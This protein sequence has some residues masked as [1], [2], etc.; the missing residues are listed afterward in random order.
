MKFDYRNIQIIRILD[1]YKNRYISSEEMAALLNVSSKTIIR[2]MK[3]LCGFDYDTQG[4]QILSKKGKG[5]TLIVYDNVK[6]NDF[7][8]Y[9]TINNNLINDKQRREQEIIQYLL[10]KENYVTIMDI[11]QDLFYGERTIANDIKDV[12]EILENYGLKLIATPS[13][14]I[15]IDGNELN[16]RHCMIEYAIYPKEYFNENDIEYIKN[17]TKKIFLKHNIQMSDKNFHHFI[18]HILISI[19]RINHNHFVRLHENSF[20]FQNEKEYA[21]SLELIDKIEN[22]LKLENKSDEA[23]YLTI[24]LMGRKSINVDKESLSVNGD[25]KETLDTIFK[26]IF[27]NYKIDLIADKE[28]Y[29]YLA[30]HFEP[31]FTRLQYNIKLSNPLLDEIK[32]K[33]AIAYDMGVIAKKIIY[34][35]YNYKLDDNEISYIAMYF[36]MA[37]DKLNYRSGKRNIVLICDLGIS[38]YRILES[39]IKS[40]YGKYINKILCIQ[41]IE[42]NSIELQDFDCIIT[43]CS[44]D[45]FHIN[46]PIIY[47]DDIFQVANNYKLDM[48]FR[49]E[50]S[51]IF[52]ISLYFP[53]EFLLYADTFFSKEEAIDYILNS[54]SQYIDVPEDLK[55]NIMERE[56]LS[57]TS[58]SNSLIAIPHPIKMCSEHTFMVVLVLEKAMDWG[59]KKAKYIFLTSPNLNN[60]SDFQIFSKLLAKL[61]VYRDYSNVFFKEPTYENLIQVFKNIQEICP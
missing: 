59:G 26:E 23:L 54:I 28:I 4:F 7:C 24:Q 52:N 19:F 9:N 10:E 47:I 30:M 43:T 39:Q 33:H 14:G 21:I 27:S 16:I 12:R 49:D 53:K 51:N 42:L 40:K 36:S 41:K 44:I 17:E 58:Y 25:T 20:I 18:Q 1:L 31:M 60:P 55:A 37:L 11:S 57:S 32:I 2:E 50:I 46:K 38:G 8:K 56:K 5:Y 48:F 45:E 35:N 13:K 6:Y 15:K 61:I 34:E 22:V 3:Y 29:N